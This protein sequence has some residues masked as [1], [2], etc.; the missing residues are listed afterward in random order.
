MANINWGSIG[1]WGK[2][3]GGLGSLYSGIKGYDLSKKTFDL[4]KRELDEERL[5]RKKSQDRIDSAASSV[6]GSYDSTARLP[7][8]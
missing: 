8:A 3:L 1:D 7:I 5:R 2:L 6:Y 4:Q